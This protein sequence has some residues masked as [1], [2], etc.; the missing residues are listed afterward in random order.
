M[1]I[2]IVNKHHKIVSPY[3]TVYCGRGSPYGNP[4]RKDDKIGE[5][6]DVIQKQLKVS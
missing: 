1:Q 2:N 5:T 4:F 3:P 6:R